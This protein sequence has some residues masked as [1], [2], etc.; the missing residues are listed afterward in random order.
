M[1]EFILYHTDAGRA[2]I[3]L[4]LE[5]GTVWLTQLEI[6]KLFATTK[7]NISLHIQNML[8][9]KELTEGSVV[10]KSL[11]T[12][13][14][15]KNYHTK[16]YRL[17]M[18]L[19]VGYSVKSPRSTQFR[20]WATAHLG[21]YLVKGFVINSDRLKNPGRWDY[22]EE[23]LAKIREIRASEKRFYQK[24]CDRFTLSTG[25]RANPPPPPNMALTVGEC[26]PDANTCT[27]KKRQSRARAK[28]S[29][30]ASRP[31]KPKSSTCSRRSLIKKS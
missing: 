28:P 30:P 26:D 12:A 29:E 23:L 11:T 8:K 15:G 9:G 27:D 4:R 31:S 25:Y 3:Q 13:S 16:L 17:E 14:D 21:E 20:Q 5:N 1:S 10:K 19:A 24:V 2:E 22:F 6:A 7:Q 18:I